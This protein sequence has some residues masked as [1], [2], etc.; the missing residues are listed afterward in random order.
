M[1]YKH[2]FS[3][4]CGHLNLNQKKFKFGRLPVKPTSYQSNR[5][6]NRSNRP[7]SR[8]EPFALRLLNSNLT[9][10]GLDRFPAKPV[11][12]TGTGPRRF[13]WTGW[14]ALTLAG[15]PPQHRTCWGL[16]SSLSPIPS[17]IAG[18]VPELSGWQGAPLANSWRASWTVQL[19]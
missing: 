18:T 16:L 9:S 8:Y 7:V 2:L 10:T 13:R 4:L 15:S 19:Y 5:P 3:L 11:Q 1:L 14:V 6:V 12:Y 17:A